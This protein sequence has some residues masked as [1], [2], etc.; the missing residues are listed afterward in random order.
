MAKLISKISIPIIVAGFFAILAIVSVSYEKLNLSL[1]III[2][3]LIVFIFF[4]GLA[5]GQNL[6]SPMKKLLEKAEDLSKG[7]LSSRVFVETKDEF[8]DLA[9]AFNKIAEELELS[10]AQEENTEKSLGIKVKARTQD[11]E[12]TINALEQKVKNRTLEL[13]KITKE[14]EKLQEVAKK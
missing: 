8:A 13:E 9:R 3:F 7:N 12:E 6:T 2:L 5:V 1:Y 14:L 4:F 11:L 10:H